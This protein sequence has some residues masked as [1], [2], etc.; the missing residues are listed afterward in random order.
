[1]PERRFA[2]SGKLKMPPRPGFGGIFGYG[3]YRF[4]SGT[5]TEVEPP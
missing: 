3:E 1:L 5:P 4:V 2:F